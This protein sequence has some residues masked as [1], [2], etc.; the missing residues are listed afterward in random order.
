MTNPSP[1][2]RDSQVTPRRGHWA[3]ALAGHE[4]RTGDCQRLRH[5]AGRV[6]Q[7]LQE[8]DGACDEG[9]IVDKNDNNC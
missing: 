6:A 8:G 1:S 7:G 3:C 2:P 9:A 4:P 5:G